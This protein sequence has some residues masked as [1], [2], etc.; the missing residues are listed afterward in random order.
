MKNIEI[1]EKYSRK[2]DKSE[3]PLVS[4]ITTAYRNEEFNKKYF[5]SINK[6]TYK[7]IE[8]IFVDSA[9]P[10]NTVEEAKTLIKRGKIIDSK[11][12]I[13]CPAGLN[14]AAKEAL[15]KYVCVVGPDVWLDKDCMQLLVESAEKKED[16][17]YV[18][19]QMSYDGKTF[20]GCGIAVDLFGYPERAYTPDGKKQIRTV[21]SA[22]NGIF[23]TKKNYMKLGMMDEEHFLF[24]EDVDLSWKA[25]L[26][27]MSVIPIPES[28]LYHFSG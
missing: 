21:F 15:G 22:D 2:L 28:I 24:A 19:W 11:D 26:L 3:G 27:G 23:L 7:N 10:D 17:I 8:I 18:P 16:A 9:S 12:N 13:G 6:Q 20:L 14:L 4:I 1:F 5:D 25:H